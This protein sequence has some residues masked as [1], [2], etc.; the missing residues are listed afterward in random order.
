MDR[1]IQILVNAAAL[2]VAVLI[3]PVDFVG[4]WWKLILVA[5]IFS[6]VNT[7]LRPILRIL[8]LPITLV[9]M[10]IFLLVINAG[11]L[12]LTG[13]VS[14]ELDLGFSVPDFLAAL[15][16]ALVISIVGFV[17]SAVIGTGLMAGR[18]A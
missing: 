1:V 6:L 11:M 7:Y 9:T 2:W 8:T 12:W 14:A 4:D 16:G 17:L 15:L 13:V 18:L 10:G 3:T 5:V